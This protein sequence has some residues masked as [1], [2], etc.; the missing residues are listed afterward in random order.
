MA[1]AE[2][3]FFAIPALTPQAAQT[4]LN[5]FCAQHRVVALER[6][7]LADGAGSHWAVCVTVAPG[8]GPLPDALKLPRGK[9]AVRVDYKDILGEADFKTYADLRAWRKATSE[10]DGVP[11]Y[12]VFTN[13]QLS[14]IVTRRVDT[15]A[16]LA[17]IEG[18]GPARLERYGQLVMDRL[19]GSGEA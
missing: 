10:R 7:W 8:A 18:I 1:H 14:E 4:E 3:H 9:S 2:Y 15:L 17:E 5:A 11:V 16:A 12:A 19:A 6:Q 13:E